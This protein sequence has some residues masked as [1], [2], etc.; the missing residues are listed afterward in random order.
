MFVKR[1]AKCT[2]AKNFEESKTI[3]FQMKGCKQGH[4]SLIKNE[5][6]PIPKRGILL[7]RP[8]RKQT[9]QGTQKEGGDLENLQRIIKK[10][11]NEIVD[12][13]RSDGEGNQNQRLYK[14]FF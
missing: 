14:P 11:S 8:P 2:L 4:I 5:S 7:T 6:Q 10:L 13:K 9:E 1:V 3:D 12:M